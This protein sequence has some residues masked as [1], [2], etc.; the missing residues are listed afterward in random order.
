M[1]IP[2]SNAEHRPEAMLDYMEAH[3]LAA[4]VT[5]SSEG[6]IATHLP[7][8]V[9]RTRGAHG[10]LAGHIA[11][12]NPQQRQARDGDEALVIFSGH[13]AYITPAFYQSKARDGKVV[14]TWNYVA[15]HA[16]GTLRFVSDPA[17]L[18]RHLEALT[19]RHESSRE[20]PWAVGDAPESYIE[21]ML[22]AIV[23]V[24]IEITRL[25]GKWKMSQ[26]RA[27]EDIDGVIAGL[28]ASSDPH[29]R[30]VAQVV[31]ERRPG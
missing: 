26:N 11:R 16:Y 22:G 24:E 13:D 6:M 7:L 29:T 19:S 3:P 5:S 8:L 17:A 1:Y 23:G 25:E 9:D 2:A 10:A 31:R 20:Q 14:P 30:E 18:R 12:A 28:E 15:V 21:R 27:A 4:L